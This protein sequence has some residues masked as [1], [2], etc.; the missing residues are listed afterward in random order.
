MLEEQIQ[1]KQ[2]LFQIPYPH[3][4]Y[5]TCK[6]WR[7]LINPLN[8]YCIYIVHLDVSC[9]QNLD[10][11]VSLFLMEKNVLCFMVINYY[12]TDLQV[13]LSLKS[14]LKYLR[15]YKVLFL[16]LRG[17]KFRMTLWLR[18]IW[19]FFF[20]F[21]TWRASCSRDNSPHLQHCLRNR[22]REGEKGK[23]FSFK[24]SYLQ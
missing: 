4:P 8:L 9:V 14:D 12:D 6:C 10:S 24:E 3:H 21:F 17:L 2:G 22:R 11:L 15:P 16:L 7:K 20:C 1:L 23:C 5:F 19:M 13:F 18:H